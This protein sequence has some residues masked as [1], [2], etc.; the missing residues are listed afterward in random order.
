MLTEVQRAVSA[1]GLTHVALL[2]TCFTI[3]T[4]IFGC[5]NAIETVIPEA[6]EMARIHLIYK[7]FC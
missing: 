3:K 5:L 6:N 7:R 1:R 2:G 4:R